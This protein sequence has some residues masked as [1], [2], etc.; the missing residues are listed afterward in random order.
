MGVRVTP[1]CDPINSFYVSRAAGVQMSPEIAF[2]SGNYLVAWTD[3]RSGGMYYYIYCA[4]VTPAGTVLDPNGVLLCRV[5]SINR[6]SPSVAF[7]GSRFFAVWLNFDTTSSITGRFINTSGQ[8]SDSVRIYSSSDMAV[9]LRLAFDGTNFLVVWTEY[10]RSRTFLLKGQLISSSGSII[11]SPFQ[12]ATANV[13]KGLM[14]LCYDGTNYFVTWTDNQVWGRKIDRNG[15]PLGPAFQV[16]NATNAQINCDVVAGANNR[17]LNVWTEYRTSYTDICGNVDVPINE[18]TE[19]N[20][21]RK[22]K[23]TLKNR[24]VRNTIDMKGVAGQQ[25]LLFDASGRLV[26][27]TR[28]GRFDCRDLKCGVYFIEVPGGAN[29]KVVKI[30]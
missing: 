2:G 29:F 28:N 8:P 23:I 26:G 4:R 1:S 20:I 22:S 6:F 24:I 27:T 21:V 11:G 18:I 30:N 12:I 17:Y 25:I 10:T 15:N 14:G 3:N 13:S 5:D 16:S 9:T 7:N 19:S